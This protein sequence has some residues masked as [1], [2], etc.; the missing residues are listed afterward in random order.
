M[1]IL[2]GFEIISFQLDWQ[3]L[4]TNITIKAKS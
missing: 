4:I 3:L 2:L 1:K